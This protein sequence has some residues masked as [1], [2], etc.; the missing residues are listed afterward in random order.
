MDQLAGAARGAVRHVGLLQQQ[1]RVT[2]R[3]RGLR[4]AGAVDA[5]ADD[6]DI[7]LAHAG[8]S[9]ARPELICRTCMVSM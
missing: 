4:N 9:A 2:G 1:H 3:G 5:G 8:V 7:D 6:G